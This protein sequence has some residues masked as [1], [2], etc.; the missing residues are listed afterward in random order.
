MIGLLFIYWIW[1]MYSNLAFEYNRNKWLYFFIGLG[2]YFGTTAFVGVVYA[3]ILDITGG[4][5]ALEKSNFDS[6]G[7]KFCAFIIGIAV[8]YGFFK[9]LEKKWEK[10]R[11]ENKKEGIESIGLKLEEQ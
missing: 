1:K 3:I 7:L 4:T 6:M 9:L 5:Q 10:E 2:V 11:V 8:C